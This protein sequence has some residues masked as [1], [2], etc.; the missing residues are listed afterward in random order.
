MTVRVGINGLGRIGKG[1]VSAWVERN[2]EGVDIVL[3]NHK[4]HA[5][6]LPHLL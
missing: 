3:I 4:N 5:P 1:I 6:P 2:C